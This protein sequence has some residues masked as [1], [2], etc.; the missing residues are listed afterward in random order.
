MWRFMQKARA[1]GAS[2]RV[3]VGERVLV[4]LRAHPGYKLDVYSDKPQSLEVKIRR[5][6]D[7]KLDG[8][9]RPTSQWHAKPFSFRPRRTKQQ[10]QPTPTAKPTPIPACTP[11]PL[12]APAAHARKEHDTTQLTRRSSPFT[13]EKN[14]TQLTRRS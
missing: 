14:T 11:R 5:M 9:G 4:D 8:S 12:P 13:R 7:P 1:V 6:P 2:D 10:P 3:S